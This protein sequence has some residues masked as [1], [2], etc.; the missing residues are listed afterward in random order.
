MNQKRSVQVVFSEMP[1]AQSIEYIQ[2]GRAVVFRCRD[3]WGEE[4]YVT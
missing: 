1:L 4:F 3:V 2:V